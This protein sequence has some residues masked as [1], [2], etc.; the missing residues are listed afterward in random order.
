MTL[1][2]ALKLGH[3]PPV[4]HQSLISR[5]EMENPQYV[6]AT[7]LGRWT[8]GMPKVLRFHHRLGADG[9]VVPR[10][11]IRQVVDMC[12]QQG[13][14]FCIED[15]RQC[16]APVDFAFRGELKPFQQKAVADCL[17][18]DFGVLSAPTGS[19]KTVMALAVVAARRQPTLIV[20]HTRELQDQWIERIGRFLDL[21]ADRVGRI[22]GGRVE[23]GTGITVAM[24]Q[25]LYKHLDAIVPT[26]GFLV[27]DE[28]HRCPSRTFT[29]A[30]TAF[31]CRYMLGLSATPWRRDK[32]SQLIF[33]HLGNTAHEI[34]H[35]RLVASGDV[36]DAEVILR[37]TEFK[38]YFDPVTEYSRM[39]SELT[40]DDARNRLIASDVAREAAGAGGTILVLSDRRRHCE[41]LQGLLRLGHGIPAEKLTGDMPAA[42]R[43]ALLE[44]INR[45]EVR[46]VVATGQLVGEGF[47]CSSLSSLFLATP[48][49]FSGRVIQY[50][51]R[52]L[53]PAPGKQKA[54]V[55]DYLDVQVEVLAAAA[56]ARQRV[57]DRGAASRTVARGWSA[58]S[59]LPEDD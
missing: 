49:R 53:R 19:G 27:V 52:V 42:E 41:I 38:P 5:L 40:A 43:Q 48:I 26:V 51:G 6:E 45:G 20:V 2:N 28:C 54:R 12:R 33:W 47:D 56:R 32:L 36:L 14:G 50:L 15:R 23:P 17:A 24:V 59:P 13:I 18:K 7:R 3:L 30:V 31:D 9:L 37:E 34:E 16:L 58:Q 46:V 25:T 1:S 35:R 57:Y 10:G 4:L 21:P 11:F 22:G 55:F 8:R 29:E 44:R 39:L